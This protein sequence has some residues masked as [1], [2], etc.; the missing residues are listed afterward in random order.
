MSELKEEKKKGNDYTWSFNVS[1]F[2]KNFLQK[3]KK[4]ERK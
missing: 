3:K 2:R 1:S 4:K